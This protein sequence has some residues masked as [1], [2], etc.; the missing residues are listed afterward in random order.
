MDGERFMTGGRAFEEAQ[1]S[2]VRSEILSLIEANE[3]RV[4]SA[5][6][7]A[8]A[9][10]TV[11]SSL[12]AGGTPI[13]GAAFLLPGPILVLA[14]NIHVVYGRRTANMSA[15]LAHALDA[16]E[17]QDMNWERDVGVHA[18]E[19]GIDLGSRVSVIRIYLLVALV[20]IG[21]ALGLAAY[22]VIV[23]EPSRLFG[24]TDAV[25]SLAG[26]VTLWLVALRVVRTSR[27]FAEIRYEM[28]DFWN[29]YFSTSRECSGVAAQPA[30]AHGETVADR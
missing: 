18:R 15:Y 20:C 26:G 24:V 14:L 1:Y 27:S 11:L 6:S 4:F 22:E 2:A 17:R 29:K 28:D 30:E 16:H 5:L 19:S 12:R 10:M 3:R 9:L 8:L 25:V 7:A 21:A 13:P 23:G